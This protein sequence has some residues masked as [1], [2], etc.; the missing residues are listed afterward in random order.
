MHRRPFLTDLDSRAAVKGSRDP[1]GQMAIWTRLGRH[2]VGNLTTVSSS[3]RDFTVLLLGFWFVEQAVDA[4]STEGEVTLFLKWEQL[5]GYAR[6]KNGEGRG[7]RGIERV[8]K[9]LSDGPRVTISGDR[10]HHILGNQKI[11]GIW[12]LY[13]VPSRT[14]GFIQ[15]EPARLTPVARAFVEENYIRAFNRAGFRQ[16]EAVCRI[17]CASSCRIDHDGK[18]A[19]LLDVLGTLLRVNKPTAAERKFY[20]EHLVQGGPSD[21]TSGRQARLAVLLQRT[22][23]DAGY[24]LSPDAV[25]RL[26][27][28]AKNGRGPESLAYHLERI[29]CAET[30]LAPA[31]ALFLFLCSRHGD[32][33]GDVVEAVRAAWGRRLEHLDMTGL[34]DLRAELSAAVGGPVADEWLAAARALVGGDLDEAIER[35]ISINSVV[36]KARGSAG[37][38][39]EVRNDLFHVNFRE[40]RSDLPARK[41]VPQLWRS[42][43]FLDSLRT[44][45]ADVRGVSA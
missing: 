43:Y 34:E 33:P 7:F 8:Q 25:G 11:Y 18:D 37:A 16:G 9:N 19:K 15:G 35:L 22:L 2:V 30:L 17:L 32:R 40:D 31:S 42:S 26:A 28:Q 39:I 1:L 13:T 3:Y 41:D 45:T 12:G 36:M 6:A 29:R 21:D 5:A 24:R 4:G 20:D 23:N 10:A 44:V 27:S 14:S 38:W